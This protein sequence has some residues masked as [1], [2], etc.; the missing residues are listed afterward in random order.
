[1]NTK[2]NAINLFI[3][4]DNPIIQICNHFLM[5]KQIRAITIEPK[6]LA[7]VY[8]DNTRGY[9]DL[10]TKNFS[11][12]TPNKSEYGKNETQEDLPLLSLDVNIIPL[13]LSENVSAWILN[14]A[15]FLICTK[16][17]F[18]EFINASVIFN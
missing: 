10:D 15:T 17:V 6:Q 4:T 12:V 18:G 14:G 8:L 16:Y 7:I 11:S 2:K 5:L 13:V 1:M 9:F 3:G